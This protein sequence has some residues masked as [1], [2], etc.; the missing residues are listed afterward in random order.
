MPYNTN[1]VF[2][3]GTCFIVFFKWLCLLQERDNILCTAR[4][5]E[6]DS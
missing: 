1:A 6:G 4:K 3:I 2:T 5:S